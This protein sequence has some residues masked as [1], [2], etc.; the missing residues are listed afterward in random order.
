MTYI[1]LS[2]AS[3]L[4]LKPLKSSK[5]NNAQHEAFET[6]PSIL[7][8]QNCLQLYIS[9]IFFTQPTKPSATSTSSS[10]DVSESSSSSPFYTDAANPCHQR[11]YFAGG[12]RGHIFTNVSGPKVAKMANIQQLMVYQLNFKT[13]WYQYQFFERS[14]TFSIKKNM[15]K[16]AIQ[17]YLFMFQKC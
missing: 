13:V 14:L 10:S 16:H 8:F 5:N 15:E 3:I 2:R 6:P 11:E 4:S 17:R 7:D 12:S 9:S 1:R